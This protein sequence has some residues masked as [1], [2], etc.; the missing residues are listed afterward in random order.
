[1][2]NKSL[3]TLL[4][5]EKNN[6]EYMG[7]HVVLNDSKIDVHGSFKNGKIK[8]I[9]AFGI[10]KYE[11]NQL[12]PWYVFDPSLFQAHTFSDAHNAVKLFMAQAIRHSPNR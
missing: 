3:I 9:P 4:I 1:M 12:R 10:A 7:W 5:K 8:K 2:K 6:L 11:E